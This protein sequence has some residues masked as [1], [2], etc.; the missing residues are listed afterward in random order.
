M[1][2]RAPGIVWRLVDAHVLVLD[3]DGA[4]CRLS[5][6]AASVWL[7]LDTSG[8]ADDLA[9]RFA[10]L[11]EMTLPIELIM[12]ALDALIERSLVVPA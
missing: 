1:F 2:Q 9:G 8:S 7:L 5:G 6:Q 3:P 10:D 11:T 12:K 4:A